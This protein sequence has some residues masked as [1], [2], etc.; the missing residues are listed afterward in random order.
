MIYGISR[1]N[2]SDFETL[3]KPIITFGLGISLFFALELTGERK[4]WNKWLL[5]AGGILSLI[6]FYWFSEFDPDNRDNMDFL[7]RF[8][9]LGLIFHL[10]ASVLPY[11]KLGS[12]Q[13]FWNYNKTLFLAILTAALYSF[14][15]LAGLNLAIL[16]VDKLFDAN[17]DGKT[18]GYVAVFIGVYGN[19]ALFLGNIPSLE[20]IDQELRYPKGLK[21]FTQYVLLPLVALYLIILLSYEGK[22]LLQWELPK[23]WVSN[24]VLASGVFGILAFLLLYPIKTSTRWI[25]RFNKGYY[26]LLLPLLGLM[27]LAIY[28]RINQYGVTEPRYFVAILSCWLLA[29][30][31]YFIVS[32]KDEIWWIPISL[33]AVALIALFGPLNAANVAQRNQKKRLNKIISRYDLVKDGVFTENIGKELSPEDSDQLSA[34]LDYLSNRDWTYLK[35][36]IPEDQ[37]KKLDDTYA[38]GREEAIWEFMALK[39]NSPEA[40]KKPRQITVY[41][42]KG[43]IERAY[44]ADFVL[45]IETRFQEN[46]VLVIDS[47]EIKTGSAGATNL[48]VDINGERLSFDFPEILGYGNNMNSEEATFKAESKNWEGILVLDSFYKFNTEESADASGYVYLIRKPGQTF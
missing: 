5:I 22:I 1:E 38:E 2:D 44:K 43:R 7:I 23:G 39:S 4:W 41:R 20:E 32:K 33:M 40:I 24:L 42:G 19:T 14:T 37:H 8:V 27:M 34:S 12:Q 46:K 25:R 13:K 31:L 18:Y 21:L 3:I 17:I 35:T 26:W 47:F 36:F 11:L 10:L 29:I 48:F 6:A 28:V 15:L 9:G 45:Q 16:A 30:S